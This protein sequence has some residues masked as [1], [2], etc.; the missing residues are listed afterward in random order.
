MKS[1]SLKVNFYHFNVFDIY[2]MALIPEIVYQSEHIPGLSE[3]SEALPPR[4]E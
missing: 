4:R 1:M 2:L 3:E